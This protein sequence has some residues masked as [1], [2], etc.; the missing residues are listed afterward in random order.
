VWGG[1]GCCPL[2]ILASLAATPTTAALGGEKGSVARRGGEDHDEAGRPRSTQVPPVPGEEERF[3]EAART[4]TSLRY[5]STT[6]PL[7]PPE[8]RGLS[9]DSVDFSKKKK[10]KGGAWKNDKW[11]GDKW[12]GGGNKGGNKGGHTGGDT[13]DADGDGVTGGEW[14]GT[15]DYGSSFELYSARCRAWRPGPPCAARATQPSAPSW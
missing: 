4:S 11:K 6:A 13:L 1:T 2:V 7:P 12:K 5:D 14:T 3:Y 9:R 8:G 15:H 10:T